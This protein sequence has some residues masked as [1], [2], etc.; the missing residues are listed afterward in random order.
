MVWYVCDGDDVLMSKEEAATLANPFHCPFCGE[1]LREL[2]DEKK[3]E[4][5]VEKQ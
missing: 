1:K 5:E 2:K 4:K 3:E